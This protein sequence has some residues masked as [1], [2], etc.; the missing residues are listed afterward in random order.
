MAS[1]DVG[2]LIPAAGEGLRAGG[3]GP[4]QFRTI[5]GIPMLLRAV[6][7]FAEHPRVRE[8]VIALPPQQVTRSPAWLRE[9]S[10]ETVRLVEGGAN[11]AESVQRALRVLDERCQIVLVH[12][13]AR[14]F[15]TGDTIDAVIDAACSTGAVAAVAVSDT[16]KRTDSETGEI[17][18]T[19]DRR[20]M[21]RA[22]TPQGFPRAML[23]EAYNQVNH[24]ELSGFTDDAA[25]VT[26]AGFSVRLIPDASTNIK[27]TTEDDFRLAEALARQ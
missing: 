23:E 21:W 3:Q 5:A 18:D 22:Q 24:G 27:I 11:R 4:K 20:G 14:P 9:I 16:L 13:A 8:I 15:V 12:D 19:I 1:P 10:D 6:R 2:V 7:P 17:I 26:A 25:L